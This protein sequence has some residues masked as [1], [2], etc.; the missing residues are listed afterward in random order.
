M[1][2]VLHLDL[3]D[4]ETCRTDEIIDLTVQVAI[5]SDPPPDWVDRLHRQ[6]S[7]H[8]AATSPRRQ[9]AP[10]RPSGPWRRACRR[11]SPDERLKLRLPSRRTSLFLAHRRCWDDGR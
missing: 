11:R 4:L 10:T 7:L 1:R 3:T 6:E 8:L 9:C 5:F 2:R